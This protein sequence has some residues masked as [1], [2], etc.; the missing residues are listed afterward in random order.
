M[1]FWWSPNEFPQK[2]Q[3]QVRSSLVQQKIGH[4]VFEPCLSHG[5]LNLE[6]IWRSDQTLF[7]AK[8]ADEAIT[9]E[10]AS[11]VVLGLHGWVKIHGAN[12]QTWVAG[13]KTIINY[14]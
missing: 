8:D 4:E 14:A 1:G 5:H 3:D 13:G 11:A 12:T 7:P 2:S 9:G 6:L 10:I